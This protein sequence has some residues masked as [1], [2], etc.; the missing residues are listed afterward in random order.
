MKRMVFSDDAVE[1]SGVTK[2][3]FEPLRVGMTSGVERYRA[4]L[5]SRN[6]LNAVLLL[7]IF[8]VSAQHGVSLLTVVESAAAVLLLLNN[9]QCMYNG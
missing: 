9:S 3:D 6:L 4:W 7:V 8:F 2:T 5:T 1:E